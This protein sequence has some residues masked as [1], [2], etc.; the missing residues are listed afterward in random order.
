MGRNGLLQDGCGRNRQPAAMNRRAFLRA[1]TLGA[2]GLS[3]ARYLGLREAQ[4]AAPAPAKSVLLIYTMGGISHHDSFDP[5]PEAPAEV[6]GEFST[7]PTRLPGVR[8]SEHVP[9]LAQMADQF[10]LLRSVQHN[11]RDHGVGAYYFDSAP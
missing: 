6:R 3:L 7:I 1:G 2:F 9:R 4:G 5:K 8:F 11:E 10:A